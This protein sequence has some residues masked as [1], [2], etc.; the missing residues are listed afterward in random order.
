MIGYLLNSDRS[1]V[2]ILLAAALLQCGLLGP[3]RVLAESAQYERAYSIQ[4]ATYKNASYG[5]RIAGT[6]HEIPFL[7]R[8][9]SNGLFALYYGV[10][11][12]FADAK[13]HLRDYAL[14]SDLNAYV[15]KLE[16]V[17]FTPC[18]SVGQ[19]IQSSQQQALQRLNCKECD[20]KETVESFLPK[21][22]KLQ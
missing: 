7:C 5:Q 10:F 15:V 21:T 18:D 13:L 2:R 3:S 1:I 11:E 8:K 14:F 6:H 20:L 19:A 17:S 16:N 4:V 12:S 9:R 22:I